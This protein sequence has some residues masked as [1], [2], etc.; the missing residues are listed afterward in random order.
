MRCLPQYTHWL[1][2]VPDHSRKKKPLDAS[3]SVKDH[4]ESEQSFH[5]GRPEPTIRESFNNS[6]DLGLFYI[7]AFNPLDQ[8]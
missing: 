8:N 5:K 4:D 7:L 1:H 6:S 2:E 3:T